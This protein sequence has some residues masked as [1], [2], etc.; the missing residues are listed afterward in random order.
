MTPETLHQRILEPFAE[1]VR[2]VDSATK[3]TQSEPDSQI[4]RARDVQ[5]TLEEAHRALTSYWC[6]P[7]EY[8]NIRGH[9]YPSG[10]GVCERCGCPSLIAEKYNES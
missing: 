2:R 3:L 9:H 5:R 4:Q 10:S 7:V 1:H 8:P 6:L